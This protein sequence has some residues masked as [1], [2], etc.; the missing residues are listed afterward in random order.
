MSKYEQEGLSILNNPDQNAGESTITSL[1]AL[2]LLY[3]S[4]WYKSVFINNIL[5]LMQTTSSI[6][7]IAEENCIFKFMVISIIF[8]N[9]PY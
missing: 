1:Y 4:T 5:L 2:M 6:I 8:L 9:I 7:K 3:R